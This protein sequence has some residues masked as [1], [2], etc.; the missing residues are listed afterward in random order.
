MS[1]TS[2]QPLTMEQIKAIKK[3]KIDKVTNQEII[4]KNGQQNSNTAVRR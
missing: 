3:A 1:Q 4:N 2:K